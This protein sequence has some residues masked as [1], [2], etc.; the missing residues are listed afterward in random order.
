MGRDEVGV[1]ECRIYMETFRL[2][3]ERRPDVVSS[4]PVEDMSRGLFSRLFSFTAP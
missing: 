4:I 3:M 1:P 2:T